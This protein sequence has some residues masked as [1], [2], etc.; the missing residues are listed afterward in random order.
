MDPVRGPLLYTP[1]GWVVLGSAVLY[2]GLA[3]VVAVSG[4]A[5]PVLKT[6]GAFYVLCVAWPFILFLYFVRLN[7]PSFVAS[8][9]RA[10]VLAA[11]A[12]A[13]FIYT[14]WQSYG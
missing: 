14:A 1:Q 10:L 5:P 7:G 9:A 6:H 2:V 11:V 13:P 4:T 12:V 3:L 8:N